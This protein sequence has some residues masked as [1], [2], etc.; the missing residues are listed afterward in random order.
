MTRKSTISYSNASIDPHIAVIKNM[1]DIANNRLSM[2]RAFFE[3]YHT[4]NN[5]VRLFCKNF[6]R[7]S[8][9]NNIRDSKIID[10]E[11]HMNIL[12]EQGIVL[13]ESEAELHCLLSHMFTPRELRVIYGHSNVESIYIRLNRLNHKFESLL[14]TDLIL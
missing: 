4:Y 7:L 8:S 5:D 11:L 14:G 9:I 6:Q 10:F 2:I 3:L 12:Q 1:S 13:K